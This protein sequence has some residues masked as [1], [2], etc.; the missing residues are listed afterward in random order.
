M[1]EQLHQ[2]VERRAAQ[3]PEAP[4]L[5]CR[6]ETVDYD[7]LARRADAAARGLRA[8]GLDVGDR[9]AVYLPKQPETVLAGLTAAMR[10]TEFDTHHA[11]QQQAV[12]FMDPYDD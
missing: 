7:T 3:A 11:A 1:I 4:A 5:L 2:L 9:V 8:S 6:G 10:V 12:I